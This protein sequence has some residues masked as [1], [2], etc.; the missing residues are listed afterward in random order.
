MY[1]SGGTL[2][3]YF[4]E[5]SSK[6]QQD[7]YV[8]MKA[9]NEALL[10]CLEMHPFIKFLYLIKVLVIEISKYVLDSIQVLT[11]NFFLRYNVKNFRNYFYFYTEFYC[12]MQIWIL[13]KY[14]ETLKYWQSL[15]Y[16]MLS[17]LTLSQMH[18][19]D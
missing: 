4:L 14:I 8:I 3:K 15:C 13:W 18:Y 7:K 1:Q 2:L 12:L 5:F 10:I 6:D 9:K 16:Y 19:E 17:N 11:L